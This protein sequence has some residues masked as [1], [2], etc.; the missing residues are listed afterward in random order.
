MAAAGARS[1][2]SC[3]RIG[4]PH[5]PRRPACAGERQGSCRAHRAP[6]GAVLAAAGIAAEYG[7]SSLPAHLPSE[8]LD[9]A[10]GRQARQGSR[11]RWRAGARCRG[12]GDARPQLTR[13]G[14]DDGEEHHGEEERHG[15]SRWRRGK[16]GARA[17]G[18]AKILYQG[19]RGEPQRILSSV[20]LS[21]SQCTILLA[22]WEK[23]ERGL[24]SL[25]PSLSV[26]VAFTYIPGGG[27]LT[28]FAMS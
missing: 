14:D 17:R 7:E 16:V 15:P 5:P 1:Y 13:R 18:T 23:R 10:P 21:L 20:S 4:T 26:Y 27:L 2:M 22:Y 25:G 19:F 3:F 9:A 11:R 24:C 6:G 28:G 8:E 12:E